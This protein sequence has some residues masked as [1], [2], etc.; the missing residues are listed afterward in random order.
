[1]QNNDSRFDLPARRLYAAFVDGVVYLVFSLGMVLYFNALKDKTSFFTFLVCKTILL[2]TYPVFFHYL[3]GQTPGK[4]LTGIKVIDKSGNNAITLKQALFREG[5]YIIAQVTA[6]FFIYE[7]VNDNH[8]TWDDLVHY[9]YYYWGG[10]PSLWMMLELSSQML[11]ARRISFQDFIAGTVVVNL[12][13]QRVS[14]N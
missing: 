8:S 2:V 11:N 6:L 3:W 1:M 7:K 9:N 4:V 5:F 14:P 12:K 10:L 13:Q